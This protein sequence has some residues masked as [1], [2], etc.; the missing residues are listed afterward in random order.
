MN[1]QRSVQNIYKNPATL[2]DDLNLSGL[3]KSW[4]EYRL[5]NQTPQLF[6]YLKQLWLFEDN[7]HRRT[8][9]RHQDQQFYLQEPLQ[10]CH[11][12]LTEN[13][14]NLITD[15]ASF[16]A[17][18]MGFPSTLAD[19]LHSGVQP[20]TSQKLISY[21][22]T[23]QPFHGHPISK[24]AHAFAS[25]KQRMQEN[26]AKYINHSETVQKQSCMQYSMFMSGYKPLGWQEI[27]HNTTVPS[28][29]THI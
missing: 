1:L 19:G 27:E 3:K 15:K 12:F 7:L 8:V 16:D 18:N 11:R 20:S 9:Y 28:I 4:H 2:D 5:D 13:I 25:N 23:D 26:L 22:R 14:N 29:M 24:I 17:H 21:P 10:R 6:D